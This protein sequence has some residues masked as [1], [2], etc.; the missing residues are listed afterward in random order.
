[1]G[2]DALL[3]DEDVR[4]ALNIPI[5]L[6]NDLAET[7]SSKEE[8]LAIDSTMQRIP[9]PTRTNTR[10]DRSQP[11]GTGQTA[12]GRK[13]LAERFSQSSK[14]ASGDVQ[15]EGRHGAGKWLTFRA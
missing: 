12:K 5:D 8:D 9:Y 10:G 6:D 2:S 14:K 3:S 4:S 13:D 11:P 15:E 1:M 7:V